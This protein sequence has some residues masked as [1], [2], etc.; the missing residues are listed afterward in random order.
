MSNAIYRVPEPANEPVLGYLPG[1]REKAELK[2][3]LERQA[4]QVVEVPLVIGGRR[5]ETG[6]MGTCVM[7]HDHGHVLCRYHRAGA[8]HMEQ[9]IRATS[10][11]RAGWQ[12]MPW[13]SRA[14]VFM[15]A[16]ELLSTRYR[17]A[18]NAAT[19]LG[20]SK[21]LYQAEIDAACESIDF[22]RFN[23]WFM[24]RIF[25]EQPPISPSAHWNATEARPLDGFV[26]AVTP[27]N[28]TSIA[29]N[30]PSAPAMMGNTVVWK[31]SSTSVLSAWYLM[32]LWRE[33][34]LP[35]GVINMV[36]G[37]GSVLGPVALSHPW[38]AGVHFTGSTGTFQSMWR[39]IGENIH[40]YRSYPRIVGETGGKDFVFVHSSADVEEV[41][42]GTLRGAFE[43]QG[44]KC[45]AASRLY[46]P[47]DL[48]PA[49]RER[50][51]D[52]IATIGMGDP[53]D[54]QNLMGAVI[55]GRSFAKIRGYIERAAA[56][57]DAEILAG[58]GTDD[59]RGWFVEPT[60]IRTTDPGYESMVEEIFGPVLTVYVYPAA[61]YEATLALCDST[62]PYAL[63]GA[64]FGR[65]RAAIDRAVDRLRFSA[66]NF[67]I[68]DK[69]TGAVVGQQPFGGGRAS[70]TNDKAGSLMNMMRWTSM[71]TIKESFVPPTDYRY[72][73][74]AES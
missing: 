52:E 17:K 67:Y 1:S 53:R 7:P 68:N 14:A 62:S 60:V 22:F 23:S 54:F 9:A 27:F 38:L 32:E 58:G 57:P 21:V 63:T 59:S 71:R 3:E 45:S 43:Y 2:E 61:E 55:D 73:Y 44:Q 49:L 8:G 56:S 13:E 25:G 31:P 39:S 24:A 18:L 4:S 74:M 35:D 66:G 34:G 6:D 36:P 12:D 33:A 28:F 37:P 10:E 69:P 41:A 50:L 48:W 42:A 16:A 26:L 29:A 30:L 19:M 70:G 11:A 20:Q 72:P 65:D 47:D 64:V 51:L 15:K 5:V 40:R 46:V